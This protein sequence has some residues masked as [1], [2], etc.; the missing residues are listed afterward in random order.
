MLC[1]LA[2]WAQNL[3]ATQS[4]DPALAAG[5]AA[6][7]P[8]S[9]TMCWGATVPAAATATRADSCTVG[10][11][12]GGSGLGK[13]PTRD[14][15]H[16]APLGGERP[17][18]RSLSPRSPRP[19]QVSAMDVDGR[20]P[21]SGSRVFCPVPGQPARCLRIP[22]DGAASPPC[23]ATSTPTWLARWQVL[24]PQLGCS[25]MAGKAVPCCGVCG[26]SVSRWFGVHPTCRAAA[27]GPNNAAASGDGARGLGRQ[28]LCSTAVKRPVC[29]H[30][31]YTSSP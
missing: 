4:R 31:G 19:A 24:S 12:D 2:R 15:Q 16:L 22:G 9:S 6:S 3:R 30:P 20:G 26:L 8:D 17:R 14:R 18:Q 21:H 13:Q 23:R 10:T 5:N 27:A 1:N 29:R 11:H 25:N 28:S 7:S